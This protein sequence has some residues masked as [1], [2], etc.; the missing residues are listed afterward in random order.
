VYLTFDDGPSLYT[1]QILSVLQAKGVPATFFVVGQNAAQHPSTVQQEHAASE[2]IGNHTWDHTDLT[3]LSTTQV[4]SEL[5]MTS[6]EIANLTGTRPTLWRPPYGAFNDTVTQIASSLGLSMRLWDVD[7]ADF[8]RPGVD[9][10]VNG[11]V[12]NVSNGAIVLLHD[13][14]PGDN[15]D[16]SQTVAA[17]PQI[18]DTL[19]AAG[20]SFGSLATVSG[21]AAPNAPTGPTVPIGPE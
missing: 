1:P 17:V 18:I 6:D 2:G 10:I 11:V 4:R 16:R 8:N 20:Y 5:Q 21:A 14:S 15:E 3:T 13:G 12:N 19:R 9:A 7:P